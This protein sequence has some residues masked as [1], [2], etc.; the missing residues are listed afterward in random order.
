MKILGFERNCIWNTP[1]FYMGKWGG[2]SYAISLNSQYFHWFRANK[3]YFLGGLLFSGMVVDLVH[4]RKICICSQSECANMAPGSSRM[5]SGSNRKCN[6]CSD[7]E[8]QRCAG[9]ATAPKYPNRMQFR[10]KLTI[11]MAMVLCA[12]ISCYPITQKRTRL[13]I[14]CSS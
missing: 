1:P 4:I 3:V 7:R 12:L 14:C 11:P 5:V 10:Y 6:W 8:V 2:L 9:S 13:K